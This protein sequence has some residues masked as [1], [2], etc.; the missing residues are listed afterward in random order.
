M[1]TLR[2]YTELSQLDTFED[3]FDYLALGGEV[4]QETFGFERWLNQAFY[5]SR[6]WKDAR[7]AAIAR[8]FGFNLGVEGYPI[9]SRILVHHMNPIN[10]NSLIHGERMLLD[11]ENLITTDH[12]TH[13]AIHYGDRNLLPLPPVERSA[14]DTKLW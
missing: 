14:N 1:I 4:G 3:R 10:P 12:D 7:R 13:N 8:D 2:S 11:L 5:Q 9:H 6:E